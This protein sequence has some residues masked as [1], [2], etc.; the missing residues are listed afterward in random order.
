[1]GRASTASL[2]RLLWPSFGN[3][4][5]GCLASCPYNECVFSANTGTL[6]LPRPPCQAAE[7]AGLDPSEYAPRR[8]RQGDSSAYD[9]EDY[10]FAAPPGPPRGRGRGRGRGAGRG[11]PRGHYYEQQQQYQQQYPGEQED[12]PP[13]GFGGHTGGSGG[14]EEEGW[15]APRKGGRQGS[16]EGGGGGRGGG[17]AGGRGRGG[18]GSYAERAA[19]GAEAQAQAQVL[20]MVPA[21]LS[22]ATLGLMRG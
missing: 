4:L 17:A 19:Q 22:P 9:Q 10:D 7:Q 21:S 13:P 12:Y 15:S 1:M 18:G 6:P 16:G 20:P 5:S 14:G 8:R 3:L 11:V 2:S